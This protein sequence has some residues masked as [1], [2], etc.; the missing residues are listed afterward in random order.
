MVSAPKLP[1]A[2]ADAEL[3]GDP[4]KLKKIK[5]LKSVS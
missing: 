4:E 3:T 1:V 5:K 2:L